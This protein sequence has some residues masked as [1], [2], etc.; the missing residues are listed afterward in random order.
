MTSHNQASLLSDTQT[1]QLA[2]IRDLGP[3]YHLVKGSNDE[4]TFFDRLFDLWFLRWPLK[5]QDYE[6]DADF[7]AHGIGSKKKV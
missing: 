2:F 1:T 3:Y 4:G 6:G 5:L 7:L